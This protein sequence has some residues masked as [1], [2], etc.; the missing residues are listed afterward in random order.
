[1]REFTNFVNPRHLLVCFGLATL[2][3]LRVSDRIGDIDFTYMCGAM[4]LLSFVTF[5]ADGFGL[6]AFTDIEEKILKRDMDRYYQQSV[7]RWSIFCLARKLALFLLNLIIMALFAGL[8][9]C[10]DTNF[11]LANGLLKLYFGKTKTLFP[12]IAILFLDTV[13]PC[14]TAFIFFFLLV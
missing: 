2:S 6:P 5:V 1:M 10:L 11:N 8:V 9:W 12:F 13:C 14:E 7:Y 3:S 4:G